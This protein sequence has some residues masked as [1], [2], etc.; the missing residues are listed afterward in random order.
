MDIYAHVCISSSLGFNKCVHVNNT[1]KIILKNATGSL[2]AT[3]QVA[4]SGKNLSLRPSDTK[5]E[6]KHDGFE[7]DRGTL[8]VHPVEYKTDLEDCV[9]NLIDPPARKTWP[10]YK[11]QIMNWLKQGLKNQFDKAHRPSITKMF[12]STLLNVY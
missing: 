10:L 3:W 7:L 12:S 9:R 11:E 4:G 2:T 1:Q 5:V 8:D 6:I